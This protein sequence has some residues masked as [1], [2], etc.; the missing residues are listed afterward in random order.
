[1]ERLH[2]DWFRWLA[3][4]GRIAGKPAQS[5]LKSGMT[6]ITTL[7]GTE[8]LFPKRKGRS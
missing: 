4:P 7:G 2:V 3:N 6:S 5:F 1:M 8:Y